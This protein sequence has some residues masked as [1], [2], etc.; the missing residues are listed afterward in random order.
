MIILR[1]SVVERNLGLYCTED[2]HL[3][4]RRMFNKY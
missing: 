2:C 4:V 1:N 3:S